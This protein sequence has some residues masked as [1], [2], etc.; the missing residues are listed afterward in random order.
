MCF[1]AKLCVVLFFSFRYVPFFPCF[2]IAWLFLCGFFLLFSF[3][4]DRWWSG[5]VACMA[6][7][8]IRPCIFLPRIF[9]LCFQLRGTP[10]AL[11]FLIGVLFS[12]NRI[13][14]WWKKIQE[15]TS[16]KSRF[17]N[18]CNTKWVLILIDLLKKRN[19]LHQVI[20]LAYNRCRWQRFIGATC[21]YA[22]FTAILLCNFSLSRWMKTVNIYSLKN[23]KR[24]LN[25]SGKMVRF[26]HWFG[27]SIY[28]LI[29][30][31]VIFGRVIL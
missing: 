2:F 9:K 14:R 6:L 31:S 18:I 12:A 30:S 27:F 16:D 23:V 3:V 19:Q 7:L 26:V 8:W 15:G 28:I 1:W 4:Y 22:L 24:K 25:N 11:L 21:I 29:F 13:T 20:S 17:E 10:A 5:K